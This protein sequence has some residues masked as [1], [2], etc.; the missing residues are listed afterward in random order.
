MGANVQIAAAIAVSLFSCTFLSHVG[1]ADC[2]P[3]SYKALLSQRKDTRVN[4]T[5]VSNAKDDK[6]DGSGKMCT[7][8][9]NVNISR[10]CKNEIFYHK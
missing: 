4:E 5:K 8:A 2:L 7:I 10:Q 6:K 9:Q 1:F 3:N